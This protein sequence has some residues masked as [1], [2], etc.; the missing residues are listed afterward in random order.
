[1]RTQEIKSKKSTVTRV[2]PMVKRES[3]TNDFKKTSTSSFN[4]PI[5]NEY[6]EIEILNEF[7]SHPNYLD[8]YLD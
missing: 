6:D 7:F 4:A 2:K 5:Y 3:S 8:D 1:M